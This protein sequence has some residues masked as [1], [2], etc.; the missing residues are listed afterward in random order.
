MTGVNIKIVRNN[1][2]KIIDMTEER[3]IDRIIG[4]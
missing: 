3:D 4:K 2:I 1:I